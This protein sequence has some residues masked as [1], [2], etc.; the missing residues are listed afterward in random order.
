[1]LLRKKVKG[2]SSNLDL[3]RSQDRGKKPLLVSRSS[4]EGSTFLK[5]PDI[6]SAV[7]SNINMI[8]RKEDQKPSKE[9]AEESEN[10]Y[11]R[12]SDRYYKRRSSKSSTHHFDR[13]T[14]FP[15]QMRDCKDLCI[16]E[17]NA[18][19]MEKEDDDEEEPGLSL[20]SSIHRRISLTISTNGTKS[21]NKR[22]SYLRKHSSNEESDDE[23]SNTILPS[24][25][26]SSASVPIYNR[27]DSSECV[28]NNN[29]TEDVDTNHYNKRRSSSMAKALFDSGSAFLP[30][31]KVGS[32][33]E[34]DD[35]SKA[36][37]D[38][39]ET[40]NMLFQHTPSQS[41]YDTNSL[42]L[43]S[44]LKSWKTDISDEIESGLLKE[45]ILEISRDEV[46]WQVFQQELKKE[47]VVTRTLTIQFVKKF[48]T[49]HMI[50]SDCDSDD[51]SDIGSLCSGFDSRISFTS[52][53]SSKI[54]R[55][56]SNTHNF[57]GKI[58][59]SIVT[60]DIIEEDE[61]HQENE[62][63]DYAIEEGP[64]RKWKRKSITSMIMPNLPTMPQRS[65]S[66]S[67]SENV[68]SEPSTLRRLSVTKPFFSNKNTE[69]EVPSDT[70]N[71]AKEDVNIEH[72]SQNTERKPNVFHRLSVTR[73]SSMK[74]NEEVS[75]VNE[76][77]DSEIENVS[78]KKIHS[79][80][81]NLLYESSDEPRFRRF[82]APSF[83]L[84]KKNV[85]R[86][87]T[88]DT[89]NTE[90]RRSVVRDLLPNPGRFMGKSDRNLDKKTEEEIQEATVSA[91]PSEDCEV[92][93]VGSNEDKSSYISYLTFPPSFAVS[94]L[95]NN[96]F[97]NR[98]SRGA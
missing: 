61:D 97:R 54:R 81:Q 66:K 73:S 51:E 90:R 94:K 46:L 53:I 82:S 59:K 62:D 85:D 74:K 63:C 60:E 69:N 88:E 76:V 80:P 17:I 52:S 47:K 27:S 70:E 22:Q 58:D 49:E 39:Q 33:R 87:R 43:L 4:T 48:I 18:Q 96:T 98:F 92:N 23:E 86:A 71:A 25:E 50:H 41:K 8:R 11:R 55:L 29:V 5:V 20:S 26:G 10:H 24:F 15:V 84:L 2:A 95:K 9:L 32:T 13:R 57:F 7:L 75:C 91:Q 93:S 68:G 77:D 45:K 21:T 40:P 38:H 14:T 56:S 83:F 28:F 79:T 72:N 16:S 35:I 64:P 89:P 65:S 19:L 1:M 37:S 42:P 12:H 31:R 67:I 30:R 78:E 3:V 44:S 34:L 6:K 36:L